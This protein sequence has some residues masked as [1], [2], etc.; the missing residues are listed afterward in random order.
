MCS[1]D[2]LSLTSF[3]HFFLSFYYFTHVEI[4]FKWKTSSQ[5]VNFIVK[6]GMQ[7][8]MISGE[9]EGRLAVFLWFFSDK[10]GRGGRQFSNFCWYGWDGAQQTPIIYGHHMWTTPW[11]LQRIL[12][13]V[14]FTSY[15]IVSHEIQPKYFFL[16]LNHKSN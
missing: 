7:Q 13:T 6:S 11:P 4:V 12:P 8:N 9:G 1:F 5:K 15:K 2:I 3:D 14:L 10:G 16:H